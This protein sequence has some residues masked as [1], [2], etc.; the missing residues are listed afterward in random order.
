[1]HRSF[2]KL[3]PVIALG[4]ALGS[5]AAP[6]AQA[7]R[8][9]GQGK[10]PVG[11]IASFDGTT[12]AVTLVFLARQAEKE[13]L[14]SLMIHARQLKLLDLRDLADAEAEQTHIAAHV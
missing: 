4:L 12:L 10:K 7:H 14:R 11:T 6:I 9:R 13:Y 2:R 1:M 5:V 3:A 8:G